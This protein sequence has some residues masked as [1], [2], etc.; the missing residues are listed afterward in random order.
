MKSFFEDLG[1]KIGETAETVTNKAGEA[2]E[3]QRLRNQIRAL[4]R[5]NERDYAELG[6]MVYNHYKDGEVVDSEAIGICD[7]IQNREES[8]GKYE[9]QISD[10]KGDVT[11]GGCGKSVAKDMAFC[12]H[13]GSKVPEQAA[14]EG[15]DYADA[16]KEKV[17]DMAGKVKEKAEA[18][19]ETVKEK[20]E[21]T[22]E[23]MK[24]K[25]GTTA[26]NVRDKTEEAADTAKEKT[27]DAAD[28][29]KEKTGNAADTIKE[30]TENA[31]DTVKERTAQAAD[32][33][34]EKTAEAAGT[35]KEKAEDAAEAVK[36]K[37]KEAEEKIKSMTEE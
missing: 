25:A 33:V 11:C 13:C 36:E 14:A 10:V 26:E 1:R 21:S 32:A 20:A 15:G 35:L 29:I 31:A 37:A 28:T 23:A 4:E 24:E 12:P 18:A 34:K 17:V 2:V 22:V 19:A 9:Q 6:K 7:A 16:V 30:K 5:G 3:V 27:E 8:I